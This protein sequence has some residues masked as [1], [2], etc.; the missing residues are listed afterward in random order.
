MHGRLRLPKRSESS[1]SFGGDH[2]LP[3]ADPICTERKAGFADQDASK[4]LDE[5]VLTLMPGCG[6]GEGEGGPW[7]WRWRERRRS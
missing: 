2:S 4:I 3:P 1:V 6:P 7:I 5:N